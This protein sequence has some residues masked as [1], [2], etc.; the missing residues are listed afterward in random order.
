MPLVQQG[1]LG[2]APPDATDTDDRMTLPTFQFDHYTLRPAT[3]DD[4]PLAAVWTRA[5]PEHHR[6]IAP[7]FWIDGRDTYLLLDEGQ[8]AFFF[9]TER[10]SHGAV[11]LFIQF[12]P[13]QTKESRLRNRAALRAGW[14]WLEKELSEKGFP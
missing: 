14:H 12:D 13:L 2:E 5:D 7:E 8:P 4:F 3:L 1:S 6:V 11:K 10:T 9:K